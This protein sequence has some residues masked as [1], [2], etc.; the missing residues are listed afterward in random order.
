MVLAGA[1]GNIIDSVFYG[2]LFTE[3]Y[4]NVA[5]FSPGNGYESIFHGH[6]VDMLQF[7]M[8]TW[9]WPIWL[10]YIGGESF[11]F[12]EPVFN[13]ADSSISIGVGIMLLF[14]KKIFPQNS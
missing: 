3:S 2:Y 4:Y 1:I 9:E 5:Q 10:P 14:N 11:T 8:L 7:P 12:F 13:I 6:V